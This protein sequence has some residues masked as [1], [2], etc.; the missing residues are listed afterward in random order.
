MK[1]KRQFYNR[2]VDKKIKI[3]IALFGISFI[4][5]LA[6]VLYDSFNHG[7]PFHYILFFFVGIL[8]S[9]FLRKVIGV[10]W[11]SESQ[12]VMRKRNIL[13][14]VAMLLIMGMRRFLF[15]WLLSSLHVV[16]VS[17]ALMLV[18]VGLFFGRAHSLARQSEDVVF[19]RFMENS[20]IEGTKKPGDG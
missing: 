8:F 9:L 5:M 11:D 14:F 20:T 7:L 1:T 17:D 6:F 10:E 16:F 3:S 18:A 13:A 15:P 19:D 4:V 2:H 12:K